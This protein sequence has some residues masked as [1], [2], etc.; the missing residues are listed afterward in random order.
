MLEWVL[1]NNPLLVG[2]GF[3]TLAPMPRTKETSVSNNPLL[4]G[5]G[6]LTTQKMIAL[7]N[8]YDVTIPF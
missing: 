4:V 5:A 2:A 1:C 6:F 8:P 3:L 7:E